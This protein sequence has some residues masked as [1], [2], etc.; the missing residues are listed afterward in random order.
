VSR[1]IQIN[2][3][4]HA[5]ELDADS[6]AA[7][8][9]F[10]LEAERAPEPLEVSIAL[11]DDAAIA[12]LN[13]RY[14]EHEGPTDVLAFPMGNDAPPESVGAAVLGDVVI[15]AERAVAYC[16]D[17]GGDPLDEL[18]LYLVHGLLHLL[19]YDDLTESDCARMHER[20]D[21]LLR[22]AADA[23]VVLRGRVRHTDRGR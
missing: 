17:H 8:A 22:H 14:L 16:R 23:G 20:Q 9:A 21:E 18:A 7:L 10:V 3:A 5:L 4:Q 1:T 13:A 12:E 2:D 11:V 15:S 6:A 19:G